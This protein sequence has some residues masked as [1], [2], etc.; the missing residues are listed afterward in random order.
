MH[1]YLKAGK[2]SPCGSWRQGQPSFKS[3]IACIITCSDWV[4][5]GPISQWLPTAVAHAG[6]NRRILLLDLIIG[7]MKYLFGMCCMWPFN[8]VAVGSIAC[9]NSSLHALFNHVVHA[10]STTEINVGLSRAD[11]GGACPRLQTCFRG[12]KRPWPPSR[13]GVNTYSQHTLSYKCEAIWCKFVFINR[14]YS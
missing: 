9:I 2:C 6:I 1:I 11:P 13:L 8:R 14:C 5:V 12:P 3:V 7:T 4:N 10:G